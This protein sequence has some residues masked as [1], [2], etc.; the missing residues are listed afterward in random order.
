MFDDRETG[1]AAGDQPQAAAV[2]EC[3]LMELEM[4]RERAPKL[5]ALLAALTLQYRPSTN[6][7]GP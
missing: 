1:A 2:S 3:R 4:L 5:R 6:G 7:G